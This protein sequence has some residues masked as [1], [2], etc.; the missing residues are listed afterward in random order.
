VGAAGRDVNDLTTFWHQP[1][2][3][4]A[5]TSFWSLMAKLGKALILPL[6]LLP[7]AISRLMLQSELVL[8]VFLTSVLGTI[9]CRLGKVLHNA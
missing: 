5:A 2:L 4:P 9:G 8:A 7:P 3:P 6:L 1:A